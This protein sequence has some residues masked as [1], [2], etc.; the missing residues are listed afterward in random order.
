LRSLPVRVACSCLVFVC[1][2]LAAPLSAE[3]AHTYVVL[4]FEDSAP[5]P[6]RDWLEEAMSLSL[7][8]YLLGAGQRVVDREERLLGM[9]ELELPAG[10]PLTLATSLKLGRHLRSRGD[11]AAPDR[12]IVGKFSLV[13]GQL[14]LSAR[15]LRL[16]ANA[17]APWREESGSL[18]DLLRIQKSLAHDLL[19]SD[20]GSGA[21]LASH[22]DDANSGHAFPLVAYEN[23][24]RGMIDPSVGKQIGYLRKAIEL[25]PGYPKAS[26]Q[27]ARLLAR[28]GKKEE[29]ESVL[30]GIAGEPA[31]YAADYHAFKGGLAL[32]GGKLTEAEDEARK[33]LSLR[34]TAA[35]HVLLAR[36]ARAQADPARA[37]QELD[38][39]EALDPDNADIDPLRKQIGKDA[40]PRS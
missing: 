39:A 12:L 7:S 27:L 22:S 36:I 5:D 21:N 31:P 16:D 38:K 23:Y 37:L 10:A 6:S 18:K 17:A 19:R 15:V 3:G 4:P 34:E 1:L 9:D 28:S 35:A 32:D 13:E 30:K 29:A 24:I 40:S 33:S 26:F 8:D 2:L 11:S 20:G 14:T 25:S